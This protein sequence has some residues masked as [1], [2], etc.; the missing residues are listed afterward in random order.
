MNK[1]FKRITTTFLA[2]SLCLG[3]SFPTELHAQENGI[4]DKLGKNPTSFRSKRDDSDVIN[5]LER[6]RSLGLATKVHEDETKKIY[7]VTINDPE[8]LKKSDNKKDGELVSTTLTYILPKN[9]IHE[10]FNNSYD[11]ALIDEGVDA[12]SRAT[13][14]PELKNWRYIGNRFYDEND[15]TPYR[16]DGPARFNLN[17]ETISYW[18]VSGSLGFN[19]KKIVEAKIGGE[20]GG[21]NSK[22]WTVNVRV[23]SGYYREIEVWEYLTKYRF[24]VYL[25]NYLVSSHSAYK[26]NGG[27]RIT[28]NL[29][30][31]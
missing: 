14:S 23:P 28:N 17:V 21:K 6:F 26:P 29:Y 30:K 2:V 31:K 15:G 16:V 9:P 3:L 4:R 7:E 20:I 1:L 12:I 19:I 13:A 25:S 5:E 18:E 8:I 11:S 24:D 22:S 27:L 10:E